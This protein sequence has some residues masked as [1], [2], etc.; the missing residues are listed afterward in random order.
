MNASDV[1]MLLGWL[2]LMVSFLWSKT[3]WGGIITKIA[4]SALSI[5]LF[6]ANAIHAF[7]S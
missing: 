2:I 1:V 3:K 5:G 7:L 4:L 6:L